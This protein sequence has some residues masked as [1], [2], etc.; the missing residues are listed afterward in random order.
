MVPFN[1]LLTGY[2]W[3]GFQGDEHRNTGA[4]GREVRNGEKPGDPADP[5]TNGIA[6]VG[7]HSAWT[8]EEAGDAPRVPEVVMLLVSAETKGYASSTWVEEEGFEGTGKGPPL[9][10]H[11]EADR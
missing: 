1:S 8:A 11:I 3:P 10:L 6:L 2:G 9:P 7:D 4:V 5:V